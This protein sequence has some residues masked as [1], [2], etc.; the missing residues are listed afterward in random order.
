[1]TEER[2]LVTV[3][4]ADAVGSTGL[5]E[6][7]DPEDVR[8]LMARYFS[9][10]TEVV[11]AHGGTLEKFIGDAVMAV[12]GLPV[13]HG[14]DAAR[15]VAAALELRDRV[16]EDSA[17][18]ERLPIRLGISS[19]EVVASREPAAGDFLVTGDAVNVA[20]RLQQAAEPWSILVGERA[21]R[22]AGRSFL[23][24]PIEPIGVRGKSLPVP[25]SEVIGRSE[26][27]TARRT[28]LIGRDADLAQLELV[29]SRAFNERRPFLVSVIAAPGVGKSRLLEEFLD[30]LPARSPDARIATA[31]CLPYGQRL[32]Y[33]PLRALLFQLLDLPEQAPPEIVRSAAR[34]WLSAAGNETPDRTAD[35]LAT[36]IG[37]AEV[38]LVDRAEL[39]A[40]WRSTIELAALQQPVILVV[41]D[42]HW[43][44][45]SLLDLVEFVLRPRHESALLMVAL[46]RPE[47]LDRR[48][49]WGGG[50]RN[51]VSLALE[52]LGDGEVGLLVAQLLDGPAPD[53]VRSVVAR[54]DGNPFYAGEIVR[55]IVERVPDLRDQAAVDATLAS[56]PDT[57]QAT[58]LA[59][60]DAL[61]APARRL[62]QVGS[63]FGR[64]YRLPGV[65][66]LDPDLAVSSAEASDELL[67]RDLVRASGRESFTFRH[68]LIREVAYGTLTRAAR[69]KLHAAAG[70]WLEATA[71]ADVDALAELIAYHFRESISLSQLAGQPV[72]DAARRR[73]AAWLSHAADVAWAGAASIE[74][75]RH[76]QA[77]IELAD[78]E[79]QPELYLRLGRVWLGG[80]G[81]VAAFRTAYE[82]GRD[83]NRS[84]DFLLLA[85][86]LRQTAMTRWFSSVARQPSLEEFE[87][88]RA[89]ARELFERATDERA[90]A[91]FLIAESFVPFWLSNL[92][93]QPSRETLAQA[94]DWGRRGLELAEGLDDAVLM[95]AALDGIGDVTSREY[96]REALTLARRRLSFEH[97][98]NVEER[99]DAHNVL[100]W[101]M[102]ELGDL[103]DAISTSERGLAALQ[104]GQDPFF[105]LAVA[106][107][108]PYAMAILGRWDDL[109]AA[110]ERC[111][112]LWLE[113]QRPAAGYA[114]SAFVSA[115][116]VARARQSDGVER[117][118]AVLDE[119]LGQFEE[120]HP[121]RRLQG[122]VAP[123]VDALTNVITGWRSYVQRVQHVERALAACADRGKRVPTEPLDE[124][125]ERA[126]QL[127]Q[128]P[129]QAQALRVRGLQGS[130]GQVDLASSLSLFQEIGA[131]PYA[132]RVEI[133]LGELTGDRNLSERGLV[134]LDALGDVDQLERVRERIARPTP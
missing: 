124:I 131:R 101:R 44:S 41:E 50:R 4:F 18:G 53:I 47:L 65:V 129:L 127:G 16:R 109:P 59:R 74:A 15:A 67:T 64:S 116:D 104:P 108:R 75:A 25:A 48:P 12:F 69:I 82:L 68:I 40:A 39:F 10:A 85:L 61:P 63:V 83:L 91:T 14:D 1:M 60:L 132:G 52:P 87:H 103:E 99:L 105:A 80:D 72:D 57:V 84:A 7:L 33:W 70:S 62:L 28:P 111:R 2:R 54:A 22:A 126:E 21:A 29:A 119:I 3:L 36:T 77:A 5:G 113:G 115:L 49:N 73:A 130:S 92:G 19:G 88:L 128:R 35:L 79:E 58:I 38:E 23:L 123:D 34:A 56:L 121:T 97:R 6:S 125:I 107:W 13:A 117:W 17:L 11:E 89:Q 94:E 100:A 37:A 43:S 26:P 93:R 66:E 27:A 51:Y 134:A 24:R 55:S 46:A 120:G 114:V 20:A 112:Q 133:E 30:R 95:S 9:I 106:S 45:D 90:R 122:F 31:Q 96:P 110:A 102:C 81:G 78:R 76:L 32:T 42:L 86:A 71:G 98:L 8:A 118:S